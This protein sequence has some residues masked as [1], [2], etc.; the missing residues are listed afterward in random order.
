M[1]EFVVIAPLVLFLVLTLVQYCLLFFAK[2]HINHA[3]FMAAR[4][5]AARHADVA[6]MRQVYADALV[7]LF[8]GG[9]T[10]DELA[11]SRQRAADDVNQWAVIQVLN[12]S[13]LSFDDWYDPARSYAPAFPGRVIPN[14]GVEIRDSNAGATS[15]QSIQD[16]NILRIRVRHAYKT[17]VFY[18][19]LQMQRLFAT[20]HPDADP[21]FLKALTDGRWLVDSVVTVQMQSDPVEQLAP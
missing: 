6:T 17:H 21:L 8:G 20:N 13:R 10:V 7:P 15:A 5:G 2:N 19:P 18:L 3:T 1:V 12:P 14:E 4:A 11:A 9:Y 16:A